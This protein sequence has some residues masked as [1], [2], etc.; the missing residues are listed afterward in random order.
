MSQ[1]GDGKLMLTGY[2]DFVTSSGPVPE[3]E[4]REHEGRR[5]LPTLL[6]QS[7]MERKDQSA[8]FC[9]ESSASTTASVHPQPEE[10]G[11]RSQEFD[12]KTPA[13]H[14]GEAYNDESLQTAAGP[15]WLAAIQFCSSHV[16][17]GAAECFSGMLEI[18]RKRLATQLEGEEDIGE[19]TS[20]TAYTC[21][22]H[23]ALTAYSS[24]PSASNLVMWE[25][26]EGTWQFADL[27]SP[28]K[29]R[30]QRND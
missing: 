9:E 18:L 27:S 25:D 10:V 17:S 7:G 11:E 20:L 24:R 6:R 5:Q 4:A 16:Y 26:D 22:E 13:A 30:C 28:R 14:T 1:A 19:H 3:E 15:L 8:D 2:S 21:R 23:T 12:L 29:K